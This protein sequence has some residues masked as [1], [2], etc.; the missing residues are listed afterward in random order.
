ML[1]TYQASLNEMNLQVPMMGD[2]YRSAR[3]TLVW[4]SEL[5]GSERVITCPKSDAA[6]G[7]RVEHVTLCCLPGGSARDHFSES[8]LREGLQQLNSQLE[9]AGSGSVWW[10]RLW[11]VQE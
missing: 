2:I 11:C 6:E 7:D 3:R 8:R 4:I 1:I 10:K 5:E 9:L